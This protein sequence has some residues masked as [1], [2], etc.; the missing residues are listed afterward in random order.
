MW[1]RDERAASG[2]GAGEHRWAWIWLGRDATDADINELVL[3]VHEEVL[4]L[5]AP[6]GIGDFMVTVTAWGPRRDGIGE[7]V[8][9]EARQAGDDTA[10]R[11][12]LALREAPKV[13]ALGH[14]ARGH[15]VNRQE[16][17]TGAREQL[18]RALQ[19]CRPS[20]RWRIVQVSLFSVGEAYLKLMAR[21]ATN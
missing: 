2:Q 20:R 5:P 14:V 4:R 1:L 6:L 3:C 18:R 16:W 13:T 15:V 19:S 9:L 21:P 10:M 8:Y 12:D 11:Q 7:T 17:T